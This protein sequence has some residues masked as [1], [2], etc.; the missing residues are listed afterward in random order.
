MRL[1]MTHYGILAFVFFISGCNIF[2]PFKPETTS[3]TVLLEQGKAALQAGDLDK[4]LEYLD[5]AKEADPENPQIRYF[6]AVATVR[7][8]NLDFQD[9]I[10]AFQSEV[11]NQN[12]SPGIQ[13]YSDAFSGGVDTL[14]TLPE[15]ELRRIIE[16]FWIV[17]DDLEPVVQAIL[18][19]R[20]TAANFAHIDDVLLSSAVASTVSAL[21]FLLDDDGEGPEFR[22]DTRVLLKKAEEAY[23]LVINGDP[24]AGFKSI[25]EEVKYRIQRQWPGLQ[26]G[27]T[28]LYL[29]YTWTQL[30][31]LPDTVPVP[32]QPMPT[33]L[34]HSLAAEIYKIAY[35]GVTALWQYLRN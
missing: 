5:K 7:I 24:M 26:K 18:D 15:S 3:P 12:F 2:S 21:I 34:N 28:H 33:N 20:L 13:I 11:A 31:A 6:H 29:Y 1:K 10:D 14:F 23:A 9:F 4:A 22:L 16:A 19:G 25:E 17:Q 27:L 8:N 32:P 35:Q 30:G